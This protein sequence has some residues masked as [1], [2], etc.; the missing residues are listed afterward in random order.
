MRK[1]E[2]IAKD[3]YASLAFVK[4]L[5]GSQNF[6]LRFGDYRGVYTV[7]DKVLTIIVIDIA[8]RKEI[9]RR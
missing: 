2:T 7:V 4:R 3:P 1:I 6:R 9:Y 5:K 8:H